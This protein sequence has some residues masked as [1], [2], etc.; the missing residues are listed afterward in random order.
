MAGVH[1]RLITSRANANT[2]KVYR[3][4]H[5]PFDSRLYNR[6]PFFLLNRRVIVDVRTEILVTYILTNYSSLLGNPINRRN[7]NDSRSIRR[8][9]FLTLSIEN[10]AAKKWK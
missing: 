10:L 6:P 4:T 1:A 9:P 7:S 2:F 8:A 3:L 5:R